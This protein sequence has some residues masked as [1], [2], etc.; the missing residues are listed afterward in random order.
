MDQFC[1]LSIYILFAD[2]VHVVRKGAKGSI[3]PI[4]TSLGLRLGC[5]CWWSSK[6]T[7]FLSI[8]CLPCMVDP[9]W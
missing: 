6:F 7:L 2:L 3:K 5:F 9:T 4:R 8:T 1:I